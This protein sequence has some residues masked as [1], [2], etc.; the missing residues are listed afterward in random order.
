MAKFDYKK[1]VT[2]NKHGKL[3][4]QMFP[5]PSPQN[6]P[7]TNMGDCHKWKECVNGNAVGNDIVFF[8]MGGLDPEDYWDMFNQPH[9]G[10]TILTDT[11]VKLIYNGIAP[12]GTAMYQFSFPNAFNG[13]QS[14]F[15]ADPSSATF[16]Q[17]DYGWRCHWKRSPQDMGMV[18]EWAPHSICVPGS[19]QNPGQFITKQECIESGCQGIASDDKIKDWEPPSGPAKPLPDLPYGDDDTFDYGG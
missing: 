18:I 3:N 4:E 2:Q 12:Q 14:G 6:V 10:D 5:A 13:I 17:C 9:P 16:S 15:G 11:G 8:H 19:A 7:C 1:W